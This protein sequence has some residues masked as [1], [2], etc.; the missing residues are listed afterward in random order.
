[1]NQSIKK[2]LRAKY[3]KTLKNI[4]P[5]KKKQW[6]E[7]IFQ[8]FIASTYFQQCDVFGLYFSLPYEVD[9]VK[10]IKILLE[11]KK[12]VALP[13]MKN[14]NLEFYYISSLNDLIADNQWN[15]LQPKENMKQVVIEDLEV[16]VLPLVAFNKNYDR[17][18]HGRGYYDR[19][20]SDSNFKALK[21]IFAYRIQEI[22]L[23][24]VFADSWDIKFN[25][26]ITN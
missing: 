16:I 24:I 3:L 23:D 4:N 26:I 18:G 1:M 21:L 22:P 14:Q 6:D 5:I 19:Y 12:K 15:I 8:Q 10:I 2:E 20:L 7:N 11:N 13:R 9:T 25:N 17:L